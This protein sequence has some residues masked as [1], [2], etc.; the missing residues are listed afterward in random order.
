MR[1]WVQ[2]RHVLH[3]D[4]C[5]LALAGAGQGVGA[6][7][8][9]LLARALL[10]VCVVIALPVVLR[11]KLVAHLGSVACK[12]RVGCGA[13]HVTGGDEARHSLPVA[14]RSSALLSCVGPASLCVQGH[15]E[16]IHDDALRLGNVQHLLP[17]QPRLVDD[18]P[19]VGDDLALLADDLVAHRHL[20]LELLQPHRLQPEGGDEVEEVGVGVGVDERVD[21]PL[22]LLLGPLVGHDLRLEL[23]QLAVVVTDGG[24]D[25]GPP[26]PCFC[27]VLDAPLPSLQEL[28]Q[29]P[30]LISVEQ[31]GVLNLKQRLLQVDALL[32][33]LVH[34]LHQ[35]VNEAQH[36]VRG[37]GAAAHAACHGPCHHQPVRQLGLEVLHL[38]LQRV[39]DALVVR[40]VALHGAHVLHNVRLDLLGTVSVLERVDGV[41]VLVAGSGH[42]GDHGRA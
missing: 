18:A 23:G 36:L 37:R 38:L 33:V 31:V 42:R 24:L 32:N 29:L 17:P 27:N 13:M 5:A 11:P 34:V 8:L 40:N 2:V 25:V 28:I 20:E 12:R 1:W 39:D 10:A 4:A 30:Q 41:V 35:A 21:A 7:A 19:Q 15:E 22:Q 9:A 16:A 3:P 14:V 26:V 6:L